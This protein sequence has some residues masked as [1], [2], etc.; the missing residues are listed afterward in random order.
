MDRNISKIKLGTKRIFLPREK[1]S[2]NPL[3]RKSLQHKTH[4]HNHSLFTIL[5]LQDLYILSIYIT[6]MVKSSW[7]SHTHRVYKL[8]I[9]PIGFVLI[10]TRLTKVRLAEK[11]KGVAVLTC[12]KS[13]GLN[14]VLFRKPWVG[15]IPLP[16]QPKK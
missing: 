7:R 4:G 15:P 8:L 6:K 13:H 10:E 2:L 16:L 14:R 12:M 5:R 3:S 1:K 11:N 9:H